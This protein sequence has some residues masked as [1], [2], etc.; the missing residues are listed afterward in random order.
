MLKIVPPENDS[1]MPAFTNFADWQLHA[2]FY[3]LTVT[4]QLLRTS[5]DRQL[6]ASCY[7]FVQTDSY[8][9]GRTN[10]CRPTV[11]CQVFNGTSLIRSTDL[12]M[13][14]VQKTSKAIASGHS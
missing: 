14:P 11:T 7:K 3:K 13:R 10:V 8:M 9:P 4:C 5:S 1:Y 6:H 12:I 2:S